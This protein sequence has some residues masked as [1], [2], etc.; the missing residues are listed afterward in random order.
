MKASTKRLFDYYVS[1]LL[2]A[3]R[4]EDIS[5]DTRLRN[6]T[7]GI[8]TDVIVATSVYSNSNQREPS[9]LYINKYVLLRE[10]I[11]FENK[12]ALL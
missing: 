11:S 6:L 8:N 12:W 10:K 2:I 1:W 9:K 4:P 7:I 3:S 5:I